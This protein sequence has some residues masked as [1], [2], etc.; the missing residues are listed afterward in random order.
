[1]ELPVVTR[2]KKELQDLKHELTVK[3]P[4]ELQ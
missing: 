3:V 2:L 1:M 4:K